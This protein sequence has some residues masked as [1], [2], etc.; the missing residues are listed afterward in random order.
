MSDGRTGHTR[1]EKLLMTIPDVGHSHASTSQGHSECAKLKIVC[2]HHQTRNHSTS[3][4]PHVA[5][6]YV[7]SDTLAAA[8]WRSCEQARF[9][10][11]GSLRA[12]R[13]FDQCVECRSESKMPVGGFD[14]EL[15]VSASQIV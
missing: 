10:S 7:R 5:Q 9:W 15:V 1:A 3:P 13:F 12:L 14:T 4:P 11:L 8:L 6:N 2:A